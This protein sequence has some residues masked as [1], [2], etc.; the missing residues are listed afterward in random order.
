M[1]ERP[2]E[3]V[4]HVS[5]AALLD[6]HAVNLLSS[7]LTSLIM[8]RIALYVWWSLHVSSSAAAK[9]D[10][11]WQLPINSNKDST[12]S[13]RLDLSHLSVVGWHYQ[14]YIVYGCNVVGCH[15]SLI[16]A[17]MIFNGFKLLIVQA[18]HDCPCDFWA[19]QTGKNVN[20]DVFLHCIVHIYWWLLVSFTPILSHYILFFDIM[21]FFVS[22]SLRWRGHPI[23]IYSFTL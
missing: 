23:T 22:S 21:K 6:N 9:W 19:H 18:S 3:G 2:G 15:F 12:T 14:I 13:A 7:A 10:V 8:P 17:V 5:G 4:I 1:V 11:R 20:I 16:Y